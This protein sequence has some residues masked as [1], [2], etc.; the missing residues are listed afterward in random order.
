[1]GLVRSLAIPLGRVTSTPRSPLA[2]RVRL[3]EGTSSETVVKVLL[4]SSNAAL[5]S[6]STA[7]VISKRYSVEN[8]NSSV[9]VSVND[10]VS[11]ETYLCVD[12]RT[13]SGVDEPHRL[14]VD[15]SE[16]NPA[17]RQV[18]NGVDPRPNGYVI[19]T[20]VRGNARYCRCGVPSWRN[21]WAPRQAEN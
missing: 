20:V 8:F 10:S 15:G 12:D 3:T 13:C 2:G 7:E 1:M 5:L 14:F 17:V 6:S 11:L 18:K 16:I 4:W 9:G 21:T 19:L